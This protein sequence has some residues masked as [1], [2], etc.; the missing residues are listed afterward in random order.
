MTEDLTFKNQYHYKLKYLISQTCFGGSILFII[1]NFIQSLVYLH[2]FHYVFVIILNIIVFLNLRN[3]LKIK[4]KKHF[5]PIF[6]ILFLHL[7]KLIPVFFEAFLIIL[8]S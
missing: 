3:P 2:S 8:N 1:F 5:Y 6:L 4:L 7:L